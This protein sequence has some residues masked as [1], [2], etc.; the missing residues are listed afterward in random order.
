MTDISALEAY[1]GQMS[2]AAARSSAAANKQHQYIHGNDQADVSTESGPVPCIAKQARISQEATSGLAGKL[3]SAAGTKEIGLHGLTLEAALIS[4]KMAPYLAQGDGVTNDEVAVA[5]FDNAYKCRV[6]DLLG[7]T[8]VVSTIPTRN[9]YINGFFKV[10]G[11]KRSASWNDTFAAKPPS[12]H[13]FGG[14]LSRLK[15]SLTNPLEQFTGIVFIGDSITWGSGNTGE[16]A[17]TDP[18]DGT[19]SD[20]RDYFGTSSYVN[21]IK[22]YIGEK[23]FFGAAPELSNWPASPSGESIVQ[24]NRQHILFPQNGFF[25][26]TSSGPSVSV[27]RAPTSGA[28]LGYQMSLAD[29]NSAGTSSHTLAFNFTGT[30]FTLS[31]GV[32]PEAGLDYELIVDGVSRGVFTTSAGEDGLTYGNDRRRLHTF[33]YVRNKKIELKTKRR[34]GVANTLSFRPEAILI[35]KKVRIMNQGINGATSV[36][37]RLYNL[38]GNNFGDGVAVGADDNYVFCQ[39]GTND[40]IIPNNRP[41][42]VNEFVANYDLLVAAIQPLADVIL[43]AANPSSDESP[44]KYSF[45]MQDVRGV[46]YR[47]A[48]ARS[49]DMIDNYTAMCRLNPRATAN[50]GLHPDPFGY[51]LMA[52]NWIDSFE[53]AA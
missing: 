52:R 16:Q 9:A 4:P 38:P 26:T 40:R 30:A 8:F 28:L 7:A 1:A 42:G 32:A 48:K 6:V 20:P 13:A 14:Q 25:T 18:R 39:L 41:P 12:F 46:I 23:Y 17:P 33:P 34:A 19:L 2:E 5:A 3:A 31:F 45:T 29:G 27:S 35:D 51:G 37:Y 21:I 43:M 53:C 36:S 50:D 24:Y 22:R 11:F 15:A 47:A 10:N 49:L 44:L